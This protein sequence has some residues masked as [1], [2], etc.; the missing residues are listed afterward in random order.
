MLKRTPALTVVFIA[1]FVL[2][3]AIA[4]AAQKSRPVASANNSQA[5][6][7][8]EMGAPIYPGAKYLEHLGALSQPGQKMYVFESLDKPAKVA[9]YYKRRLRKKLI[10]Q[11]NGK[12]F[13]YYII[14][15][16]TPKAPQN[17]ITIE[18]NV[19]GGKALSIITVVKRTKLK[20]A[21]K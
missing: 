11:K 17:Y 14:V 6:L 12:D 13:M 3:A 7:A 19:Y 20:K 4:P 1:V 8:M 10:R 2:M 21:K 5:K 15:R 16:G 9:I 18:R